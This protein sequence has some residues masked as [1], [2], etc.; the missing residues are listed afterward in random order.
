M[1]PTRESLPPEFAAFGE[2]SEICRAMKRQL[3]RM[4]AKVVAGTINSSD[5]LD[6]LWSNNALRRWRADI[7]AIEAAVR[8]RPMQRLARTTTGDDTLDLSGDLDAL[9][10]AINA[11]VTAIR[12]HP[13]LFKLDGTENNTI[14]D[15]AGERRAKVYG[16][17]E[18][19]DLLPL[20]RA[21]STHIA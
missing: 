14:Q 2:L 8:G 20:I 7:G 15:V 10:A 21:C 11:L 19:N 17:G 16:A 13:V 6:G 18:L 12:A 3:D 4:D 5:V 1:L 9:S